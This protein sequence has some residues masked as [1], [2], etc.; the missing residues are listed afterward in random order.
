MVYLV[1]ELHQLYCSHENQILDH[2]YYDASLERLVELRVVVCVQGKK[3]GKGM[4]IFTN[5][6]IER[7]TKRRRREAP[8][9]EQLIRYR[10]WPV[11]RPVETVVRSMI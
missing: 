8:L 3:V 1:D 5:Q 10:P 4:R 9:V 2:L 7:E 6:G 11:G